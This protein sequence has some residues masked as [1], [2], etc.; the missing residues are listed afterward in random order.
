MIG[1]SSNLISRKC[2]CLLGLVSVLD[3]GYT[4]V[5]CGSWSCRGKGEAWSGRARRLQPALREKAKRLA[6]QLEPGVCT[7]IFV[8]EFRCERLDY[9]DTGRRESTPRPSVRRH[10]SSAVFQPSPAQPRGGSCM[11]QSKI[12]ERVSE[13][14]FHRAGWPGGGGSVSWCWLSAVLSASDLCERM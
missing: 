4:V 14:F 6:R 10:G 8:F 5:F 13:D 7:F 9:C 1:Y 12:S 2:A 11:I 3:S